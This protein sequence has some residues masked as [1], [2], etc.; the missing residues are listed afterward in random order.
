MKNLENEKVNIVI[1]INGKKREILSVKK[2]LTENELLNLV[3]SNERIKSF[4]IDK[5]NK[6]IFVQIKLLT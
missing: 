2:D 4:M 5:N 1:Q 3:N 6:K